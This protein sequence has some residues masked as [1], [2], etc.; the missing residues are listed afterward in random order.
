MGNKA[1]KSAKELVK[2]CI[3]GLDEL[4]A[5]GADEKATEQV[6][7]TIQ[8]IK[9]ILLGK[10]ISQ[11]KKKD[12][13]KVIS[14]ED[15]KELAL[16]FTKATTNH[17]G[18]I[19]KLIS[20]LKYLNVDCKR[21]I[22]SILSHLAKT[23]EALKDHVS[24]NPQI[25]EQLV[26]SYSDHDY[27]P[28]TGVCLFTGEILQAFIRFI[29]DP[30]VEVILFSGGEKDEHSYM[31]W[32]FFSEYVDIPSFDVQTQAFNTLKEIFLTKHPKLGVVVRK[33]AVK[34]ITEKEEEFFKYF[35]KMLQSPTFVTCRQ[36]L[37]L[38][39]QVLFDPEKKTYKA[40][41]HYINGAK[42]LKIAMNLLRDSSDQIQFEAFHLFKVFVLNPKR[43]AKVTHILSKPKNV[44]NLIAFLSTFKDK[45]KDSHFGSN[46]SGA[47]YELFQ[48][49]LKNVIQ[50][51]KDLEIKTPN[52]DTTDRNSSA[53][54]GAFGEPI[55]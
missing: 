9:N 42:N 8:A 52:I 43:N 35:N 19:E 18:L 20:N 31:V 12:K 17:S 10:P 48:S 33:S 2:I 16:L 39:H 38:L 30:V 26:N 32:N 47:G 50:A 24:V 36:S 23:E 27:S 34:L 6:G 22:V 49:E 5:N 28:E 51:I 15:R 25:I 14:D 46:E 40:M 45:F 29:G 3:E 21:N 11:V 1:V 53:E 4:T 7:Q 41:M 44:K 37:M 54:L 55:E 13:D